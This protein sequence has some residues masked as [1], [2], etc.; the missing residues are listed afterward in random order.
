M[1]TF[2][3][4]AILG[5]ALPN[6]FWMGAADYHTPEIDLDSDGVGIAAPFIFSGDNAAGIAGGGNAGSAYVWL[7]KV[8]GAGSKIGLAVKDAADAITFKVNGFGQITSGKDT[9]EGAFTINGPVSSRSVFWRTAGLARWDLRTNAT[10]EGGANAGSDW[11]LNA[12]NDAGT[13]LGTALAVARSNRAA[14]FAF[15]VRSTSPSGGIGY[16]TGAG[17]TVTQL[18]NKATAV[19]LDKVTGLITTNN[20]ILNAGTIVSFV[21]NNS[22]LLATDF[23]AIC[24]ESGGTLGSYTVNARATGVGTAAVDIR[25]NTAGNLT[26]ALVL[27]FAVIKSAS[28]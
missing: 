24:H 15:S 25:N 6:A 23:I 19:T 27:R 22:A 9:V 20:A 10:A 5:T 12:Y 18:T 8:L 13:L 1:V 17:G 16:D 3:G 7:V 11:T 2:A 14:T 28:S 21:W 4:D 26:E